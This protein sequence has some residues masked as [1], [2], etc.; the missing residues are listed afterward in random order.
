[1]IIIGYQGIGKSTL[2]KSDKSY[3]DLES[4]IYFHDGVR[5]ENWHIFYCKTAEYLSKQG[6][7]VFVSSHKPV[8]EY[9]TQS[10]EKAIVICP[11]KGLKDEWISRL[12]SRY[13]HTHKDKD[14][15]AW[16][17]A[18]QMFDSNIDDMNDC[19]LPVIA[20]NNMKY[21]LQSL[22]GAIVL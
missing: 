7:F 13:N 11:D 4:S 1:M 12:E 18:I 16:Q 8:R 14:F 20:I 15:R 10:K 3:I 19:G 2:A 22:I 6:Y 9:L 17:N 5:P 21:D